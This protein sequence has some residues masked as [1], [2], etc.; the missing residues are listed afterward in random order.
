M[1]SSDLRGSA[2]VTRATHFIVLVTVSGCVNAQA[3]TERVE[4]RVQDAGVVVATP[5]EP[6]AGA[7]LLSHAELQR[8][9]ERTPDNAMCW[10]RLASSWARKRPSTPQTEAEAKRCY[11]EYLR[12]APPSE[13]RKQV[14][15]WP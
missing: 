7:I 4:R 2:G 14:G 1:R 5:A 3:P 13:D 12:L 15:D 6:D 9:V 11:L 10:V 8:C